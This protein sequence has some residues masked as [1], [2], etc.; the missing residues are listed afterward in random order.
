MK[1]AL[2]HDYL[3]EYG[4][5]ERVLESFHEI[6][7]DAPIYVSF[8]DQKSLGENA[9]RFQHWD[10]RETKLKNFPFYKKL[11]SP[12]RIFAA[13]AFEQL[14]LSD[15]EVVISSTNAY[16]SK[17]V[18]IK[19]GAKHLS[20]VHTPSRALYGYSTKSDWKK[21]PIIRVVGEL[22]NFWMRYVDFQ[23]A[24]RPDVLIANSTTTQQRITKFW[25]R[26]SV[27][28][29]PPVAMVDRKLAVKSTDEREYLLFVGRLVLSKHPE[30]AV[31]IS[32]EL[33]L[34]LKV[35]GTGSMLESLRQQA[36]PQVDFLGAV[37]DDT[38][39]E[40]YQGAKLVLFPAEDE[41]FGIVPIEALAAG[42]P[43]VAHYSGEP[44]YT[45]KAGKTGEHVQTFAIKEWTTVV[46]KAWYSHWNHQEIAKSAQKYSQ[47]EFAK[48]IKKLL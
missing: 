28:I 30:L 27:V 5:A 19:K 16:Q 15:Y 8:F 36:G 35:V 41:D 23:T 46:K 25:R 17:A 39:A 22:I 31:Q 20:Y 26:E 21:N 42:T 38:L 18:R 7:P 1:L 24:Q 48:A 34:P 2:V 14:D 32:N 11:F 10:I 3:R 37:D 44:R 40:L 6:F 12:Y 29:P 13:W 4:G 33:Q 9:A 43:V 47:A 45:V